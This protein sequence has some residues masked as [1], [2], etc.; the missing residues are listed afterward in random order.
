ME[1]WLSKACIWFLNLVGKKAAD[2]YVDRL[3]KIQ[4]LYLDRC[5]ILKT[6][7]SIIF[8]ITV[9]NTFDNAISITQFS[10][11]IIQQK[12]VEIHGNSVQ[13]IS[14]LYKIYIKQKKE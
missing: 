1:G 7:A 5:L 6:E 2:K 12:K 9:S 14:A 11:G 8:D 13:Q 10:G 4:N 3:F